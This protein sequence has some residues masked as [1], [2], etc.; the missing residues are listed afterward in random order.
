VLLIDDH[1][2]TTDL[3][4]LELE[5]LGYR[6]LTAADGHLGLEAAIRCVPDAIVSDLKLPKIDGYELI[7]RVRRF[8]GLASVPAIALTGLGMKKD[9]DAALAA[10]FDA[11][12]SKPADVNELSDLVQNLTIRSR[13]SSTRRP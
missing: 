11:H 3:I 9:V 6:V 5:S 12:M 7:R 10:G 13:A 4:K 8:P 2:D 1:K